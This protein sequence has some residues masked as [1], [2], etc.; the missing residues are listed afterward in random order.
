MALMDLECMLL[1]YPLSML[2][3]PCHGTL[4]DTV[5]LSYDEST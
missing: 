5:C 2:N 3:M 4:Y 1:T